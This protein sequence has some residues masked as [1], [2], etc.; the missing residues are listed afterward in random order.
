MTNLCLLRISF[1]LLLI[2]YNYYKPI[3]DQ[4]IIESINKLKISPTLSYCLFCLLDSDWLV[5]LKPRC[6]FSRWTI[7]RKIFRLLLNIIEI[8]INENKAY[9]CAKL[10]D[11]R[12]QR[13]NAIINSF[14]IFVES[15]LL[16]SFSLW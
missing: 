12:I 7:K 2:S 8:F 1:N 10:D 3:S 4:R 11:I 14:N 15:E 5:Y 16:V 6:L 9:F 13:V